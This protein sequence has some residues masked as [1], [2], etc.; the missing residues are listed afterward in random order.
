MDSQ[1]VLYNKVGGDEKYTPRY[2]VLPLL[3]FIKSTDVIWCPF[4]KE[5]SEFVKVFKENGN[6]VI[7]SHIDYGQDFFEYEP[8]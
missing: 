2:A 4:D 5:S 3:E 1:K 7:F 6:K 8:K